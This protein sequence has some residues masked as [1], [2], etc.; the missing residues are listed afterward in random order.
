MTAGFDNV[1]RA[2]MVGDEHGWTTLHTLQD[3]LKTRGIGFDRAL[4]TGNHLYQALLAK[5][6]ADAREDLPPVTKPLV[7]W[8][9]EQRELKLD[10]D[11]EWGGPNGTPV[12]PEKFK[13]C[14]QLV[15]AYQQV[16]KDGGIGE[17]RRVIKCD[18]VEAV[19]AEVRAEVRRRLAKLQERLLNQ[20][21]NAKEGGHMRP[22]DL[23][24]A[25]EWGAA[26]GAGVIEPLRRQ[27][28]IYEQPAQSIMS[29]LKGHLDKVVLADLPMNKA[30]SMHKGYCGQ[31]VNLALYEAAT[32]VKAIY[33]KGKELFQE[34][35]QGQK[36]LESGVANHRDPVAWWRT[37]IEAEREELNDRPMHA[38]YASIF[39][40]F[41]DQSLKFEGDDASFPAEGYRFLM[42]RKID[43]LVFAFV[44]A[45]LEHLVKTLEPIRDTLQALGANPANVNPVDDRVFDEL[46]A[47]LD[48][49]LP[50]SPAGPVVAGTVPV[51]RGPTP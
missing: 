45:V 42:G 22:Q 21:Q 8:A 14:D 16:L 13:S 12:V 6:K 30:D 23:I 33:D 3:F 27:P 11:L 5:Q 41:L 20:I 7:S 26:I 36:Q 4:L 40:G 15:P 25:A 47:G 31:L 48:A 49:P 29:K 17:L 38:W 43:S 50:P 39:Q 46:I 37:I 35:A 2:G 24:R 18:V 51:H 10:I 19:Q 1:S 9:I 28:N 34:A 44:T 32:Q